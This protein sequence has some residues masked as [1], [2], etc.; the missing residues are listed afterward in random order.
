MAEVRFPHSRQH[1]MEDN[2]DLNAFRRQWREEVTRRSKTGS[3][4][5]Q[6]PPLP[7]QNSASE[8]ISQLDHL[9][10]T[11]HEAA[12]RKDHDDE[13]VGRNYDEF[14]QRT[15]S[16]TIKADEDTF[17]RLPQKEPRSALEHFEKAVE[18]E[19]EGSLGDSLAHYRQAYRVIFSSD[20][21][22]LFS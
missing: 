21:Y 20:E 5:K 13:D 15:D 16:L 12:Q 10:P 11:K 3:T 14:V 9:P 1:K 8:H 17:Q 19:A 2:P 4:S 7:T 22:H 6:P 18:K